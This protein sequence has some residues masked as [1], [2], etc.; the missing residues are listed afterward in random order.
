MAT[1]SHSE[2]EAHST[3]EQN[4]LFWLARDLRTL[5]RLRTLRL[6]LRILHLLLALRLS[7]GERVRWHL[8]LHMLC[9]A[10][11]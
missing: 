5:R 9:G 1:V 7:L 2:T 3:E 4:V 11:L 6:L 10:L 8:R